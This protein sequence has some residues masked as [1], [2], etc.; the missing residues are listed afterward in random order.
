[1]AASNFIPFSTGRA[2]IS[3]GVI[4]VLRDLSGPACFAGTEK[5]VASEEEERESVSV[6]QLSST[7]E[8]QP[9]SVGA[10]YHFN[11]LSVVL[12]MAIPVD[13]S[14][15]RLIS[16]VGSTHMEH[17]GRIRLL[18]DAAPNRYMAL[19][20]FDTSAAADGFVRS[21]DERAYS[22]LAP[23]CCHALLVSSVEFTTKAS[24]LEPLFDGSDF[25]G[26][27]GISALQSGDFIEVPTC[28]V[29]LERIDSAATGIMIV[30]CQHKF[31]CQCLARWGD[32]RCPVCRFVLQAN[33][34]NGQ[35]AA[36]L[37][38][39]SGRGSQCSTCGAINH[40][41]LCLICGNAGCGRYNE[42]HANDHY[43]QTGH[44]FALEVAT[45]RV[46]DYSG[47]K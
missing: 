23:E 40:I 46:W 45:H 9:S 11:D 20:R 12:L 24:I 34:S 1:M 10:I 8:H 42:G 26:A 25:L 38:H 7:T 22:P 15:A 39:E 14:P 33:S 5:L 32:G 21:H 2:Q 27:E 16:F 30:V 47:D 6:Y 29:C 41:W 37:S 43:C 36:H 13:F 3:S 18:R 19:M 17:V 28:P 35:S 4:H 31:H 44:N